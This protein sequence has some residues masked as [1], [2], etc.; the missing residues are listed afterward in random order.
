MSKP[1]LFN[2]SIPLKERSALDVSRS[3]AGGVEGGVQSK[4]EKERIWGDAGPLSRGGCCI[5]KF[6]FS[7]AFFCPSHYTFLYC[8]PYL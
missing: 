2:I 6:F 7:R 8:L 4:G 1:S 3:G 5:F